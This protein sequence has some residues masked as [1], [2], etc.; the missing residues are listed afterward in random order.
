MRGERGLI[1]IRR[2]YVGGGGEDEEVRKKEMGGGTGR[3]R[4]RDDGVEGRRGG[5]KCSRDKLKE[6]KQ[7]CS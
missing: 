7:G 4:R 3:D 6:Y 2:R 1:G 5:S